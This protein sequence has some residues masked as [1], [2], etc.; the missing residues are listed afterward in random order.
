MGLKLCLNQ[1]LCVQRTFASATK[2]RHHVA[3]AKNPA[4]VATK[5]KPEKKTFIDLGKCG[6]KAAVVSSPK[7]S[8]S[9]ND[10]QKGSEKLCWTCTATGQLA[11][12]TIHSAHESEAFCMTLIEKHLKG[13]PEL[14]KELH[15]WDLGAALW[16]GPMVRRAL[17]R[18]SCGDVVKHDQRS[19]FLHPVGPRKVVIRV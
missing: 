16:L 10:W 2:R 6:K 1:S 12:W 9:S 15:M 4:T 8:T 5:A 3:A 19:S 14:M 13:E 7:A 11:L 17:V 18:D